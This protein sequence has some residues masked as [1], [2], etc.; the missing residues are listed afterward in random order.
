[1]RRSRSTGH[2]STAQLPTTSHPAPGL[3]RVHSPAPVPNRFA[4]ESPTK[5]MVRRGAGGAAA[6]AV[7]PDE[8]PAALGPVL[9][10][11]EGRD[12]DVDALVELE[13]SSGAVV[14]VVEEGSTSVVSVVV[15]SIVVVVDAVVG[16]GG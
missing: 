8:A 11:P 14:S 3:V 4:V 6:G 16:S 10:E 7:A 9:A 5:P 12:D 1:M 15:V 2:P 13:G